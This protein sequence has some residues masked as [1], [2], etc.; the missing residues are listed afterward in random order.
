MN[1]KWLL[2]GISNFAVALIIL[3]SLS[4]IIGYHSVQSTMI[5][6]PLFQTRTQ[7][8]TNQLHNRITSQYLGISN[9]NL[10]QFPFRDNR[11]EQ[12][13]KAIDIISK[14][15]DKT[16]A[17][18]TELCIQKARQDNTLK[19]ISDYQIVQTLLLLKTNPKAILNSYTNRGD[20]PITSSEWFSLCQSTP[21]DCIVFTLIFIPLLVIM[22]IITFI[23]VIIEL[24]KAEPTAF[25]CISACMCLN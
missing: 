8:A 5:D 1:R 6:S 21:F 7:R 18:F 2:I 3:V 11:T 24:I 14:M 16:F 13:K 12:L 19:G 22:F 25:T 10:L 23:E 4:N 17:Q 15:D 9:G 20:Q